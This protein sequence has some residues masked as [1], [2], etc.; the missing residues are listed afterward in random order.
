MTEYNTVLLTFERDLM[1]DTT[2][3]DAKLV[4]F[5]ITEFHRHEEQAQHMKC[6]IHTL[7]TIYSKKARVFY[8]HYQQF[9][10]LFF[11]YFGE[12]SHKSY[13]LYAKTSQILALNQKG[14][15][16][17]NSTYYFITGIINKK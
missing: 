12:L 13:D 3:A 17:K 14:V 8:R 5:A 11:C 4:R 9:F 2:Y 15:S 6:N 10:C 16:S 1:N 7:Y